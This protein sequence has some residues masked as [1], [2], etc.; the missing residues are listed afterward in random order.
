V[1]CSAALLPREA[2]RIDSIEAWSKAV[3]ARLA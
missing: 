1:T 3:L 2:C